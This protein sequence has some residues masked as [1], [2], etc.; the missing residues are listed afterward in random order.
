MRK[1]P[2]ALRIPGPAQLAGAREDGLNALKH[3][4]RKPHT[5][6]NVLR[7]GEAGLRNGVDDATG[8]ETDHRVDH[9]AEIGVLLVHEQTERPI[10]DVINRKLFKV[11]RPGRVDG[12]PA[13]AI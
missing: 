13:E 8:A 2:D 5:E 12:K 1:G 10:T 9:L 6:S 7:A 4:A 11:R 3:A